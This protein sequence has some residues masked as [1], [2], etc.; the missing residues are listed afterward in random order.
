MSGLTGI[1]VRGCGTCPRAA[2]AVVHR[3]LIHSRCCR[4]MCAGKNGSAAH[5]RESASRLG[6]VG[7]SVGGARGGAGGSLARG[8]ISHGTAIGTAY[9]GGGSRSCG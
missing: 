3:G 5:A 2:S 4:S 8:I 1:Q 9:I 7:G 6:K